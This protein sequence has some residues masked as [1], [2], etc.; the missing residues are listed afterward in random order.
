MEY[1]SRVL[2]SGSSSEDNGNPAVNIGLVF[3]CIVCAALASGLTQ[4]LLSLDHT[5][6]EIKLR[7]GT[8]QEK[9]YAG[10]LL[11]V[12]RNHHFLLVTL[13][14]WNASAMEA[15]PIF[16]N[17]LVDEWLAI[18]LSVTIVL[19]FCEILP[20][21]ILTGPNQLYLSTKLV[22]LVW[23]VFVIFAPASYPMSY[24]LDLWLGKDEGHTLYNRHNL[25]AMVKLQHELALHNSSDLENPDEHV[26]HDDIAILSGALNF[27]NITVYQVMTVDVFMLSIDETLNFETMAKIFK[28]GHSRVPVYEEDRNHVV[29][30]LLVKDLI[31]IDPD[32][33]ITIR[34][35]MGIFS[36]PPQFVWGDQTLGDVLKVFQKSHSHLAIV[37][38]VNDKGTGDPFYETKGIITL[39]DII[40]KI[41]GT[42]I[43]DET[44]TATEGADGS[45]RSRLHDFNRLKL[46]NADHKRTTKPTKEEFAVIASYLLS[47]P[48][49]AKRIDSEEEMKKLIS[50]F[51][52]VIEIERASDTEYRPQKIDYLYEDGVQTDHCTLILTGKVRVITGTEKFNIIMGPWNILGVNA[53]NKESSTYIPDFSAYIFSEKVRLLH[54]RNPSSS[55]PNAIPINKRRNSSQPTKHSLLTQ[56]PQDSESKIFDSNVNPFE[57]QTKL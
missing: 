12:I 44:D 51:G 30:L 46:L 20:A 47:L 45:T 55:I 36:R 54:L 8:R 1:I 11:P 16:L 13:M 2:A 57:L 23:V 17:K 10:K 26:H 19:I 42:D 49:I 7:S 14:L 40:E 31:F 25:V 53:L 5:E 32:D 27:R 6:L 24:V 34:K 50:E 41:I 29:G 9:E 39:E 38:E 56:L 43:N 15:L 22:P 18:L 37:Q 3:V 28:E 48:E 33:D 4:G 52:T 35:F 21:A